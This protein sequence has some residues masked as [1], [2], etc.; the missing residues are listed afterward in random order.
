MKYHLYDNDKAQITYVNNRDFHINLQF[1]KW[2][3]EKPPI[4]EEI[5]YLTNRERKH[6][7]VK[8]IWCDAPTSERENDVKKHLVLFIIEVKN[9]TVS[10]LNQKLKI[11]LTNGDTFRKVTMRYFIGD[12]DIPTEDQMNCDRYYT[13][14]KRIQHMELYKKK[15]HNPVIPDTNNG[16]III[17]R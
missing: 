8:A 4:M 13:D 16:G 10:Q 14:L 6:D 2:D 9:D 5:F 12:R 15:G 1:S 17:K 7:L 11:S 3:N